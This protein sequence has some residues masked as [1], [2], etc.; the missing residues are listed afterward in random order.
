[1]KR[2]YLII[3]ADF[4]TDMGKRFVYFTLLEL[5][6]F[7]SKNPLTNLVLMSLI[8]R[9]SPEPLLGKTMSLLSAYKGVCYLGTMLCG[10]LVIKFGTCRLLLFTGGILMASA[11]LLEKKSSDLDKILS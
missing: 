8:Q 5:L 3:A 2:E 11:A 9:Y 7:Q 10:A 4:W 6:V 1:V